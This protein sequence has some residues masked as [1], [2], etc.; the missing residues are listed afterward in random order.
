M[1]SF[2]KDGAKWRAQVRYKGK[3]KSKQGFA[4]KR[5]AQAWAQVV[6]AEFEE[7]LSNEIPSRPF[8]DALLRYL[9]Q[10]SVTKRGYKFEQRRI[11]RWLGESDIAPDPLCFISLQDLLPKHFAEWRDRR[12]AEV[13]S[14]TVLREWTI[15]SGVCR[16]CINDWGWLKEHPMK[17]VT[18]PKEPPPRTRRPTA[19]ELT[20]LMMC[21]AYSSEEVPE[22]KSKRVGA[23]I[24]F[25]C[26]TAM[27][28]G[29]ICNM[30][31]ADVDFEKRIVFLPV[32]KNGMSRVVPLSKAAIKVLEQLKGV[33]DCRRTCF[34]LKS[35]SLDTLFRKCRDKCVIDDLHFHDMRREALTR[36]ALKVDVMT[37]AK[38]S[39]HKDLRILQ[40]VYYAPDMADVVRLLD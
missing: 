1:A 26:E 25:A 40:N 33:D 19:D 8:S 12:L 34:G 9:E 15:L 11:Q 10:V 5:A 6:E 23:A 39:G 2:Y 30:E 36:M 14:G 29:E 24:V 20:R 16:R 4:T 13:S 31:W 38:I 37:L 17:K 7:N 3:S 21:T 27:R 28:A 22:T 32:T 35:A 18:R